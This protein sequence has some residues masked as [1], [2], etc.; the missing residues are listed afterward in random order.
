MDAIGSATKIIWLFAFVFG[1]PVILLIFSTLLWNYRRYRRLSLVA[2]TSTI[3]LTLFIL[4]VDVVNLVSDFPWKKNIYNLCIW[5]LFSFVIGIAC[6]IVSIIY[7]RKNKTVSNTFINIA[8][9]LAIIVWCI[10]LKMT[11]M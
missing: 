7:C 10:T 1:L 4:W 5:N 9:I 11:N 6:V 8:A 2:Y 3:V